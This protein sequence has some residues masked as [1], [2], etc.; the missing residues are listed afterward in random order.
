[1]GKSLIDNQKNQ[2]KPRK[3]VRETV[4]DLKYEME[5]MKKAQTERR[6]GKGTG[7]TETSITMRG[8]S[9]HWDSG[10]DILGDNQCHLNWEWWSM[11]SNWTLWMW[12]AM[13]TGWEA[14][15]N[16]TGFW[17]YCMDWQCGSLVRLDAQ[18]YIPGWTEEDLGLAMRQSTLTDHRTREGEVGGE[19]EGK[20]RWGR[21]RNFNK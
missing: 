19:R 15:D 2:E 3:K 11:W 1:M 4:Q 9:T 16:G 21:S 8:V 10:T 5:V 18:L 17:F 13:R 14:K 6:L 12:L 20:G 7:T